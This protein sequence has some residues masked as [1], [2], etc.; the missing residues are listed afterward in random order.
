MCVL[1][2]LSLICAVGVAL[3][4]EVEE[5]AC[6]GGFAYELDPGPEGGITYPITSGTSTGTYPANAHCLWN[7]QCTCGRPQVRFTR[8]NVERAFD[9][10]HVYD[11]EDENAPELSRVESTG[12]VLSGIT[13]TV[14][15]TTPYDCTESTSVT[16]RLQSDAS[17]EG[18]GFD[19]T[20][21]C[22]GGNSCGRIDEVAVPAEID[23]DSVQG[24][25]SSPGAGDW[26]SFMAEEGDA[27]QF[28]AT[29][30]SGNGMLN[31]LLIRVVDTDQV[32]ELAGTDQEAS[33]AHLEWTCSTDGRYYVEVQGHE[34]DTG[35]FGF[36]VSHVARDADPCGPDGAEFTPQGIDSET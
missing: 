15:P 32:T 14:A 30:G 8:F 35:T 31:H 19:A 22:T 34:S 24:S 18:S 25:V 4:S 29:G 10:V 12:R 33:E 5:E 27:Y 9:F 6:D 3:G 23:G 13:G 36:R 21:S 17:V 1:H 2:V 16:I 7:V 11:G 28:D 20:V 26:Y